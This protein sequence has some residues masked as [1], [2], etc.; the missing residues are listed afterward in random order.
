L[1]TDVS[2]HWRGP[3]WTLALLLAGLTMLGPFAIDTYLPAFSGIARSLGAT[4][5]QMQQTLS[6]YLF[7]FGVMN[8]FH[9]ALADAFGRRPVVLTGIAVFTLASLGCALSQSI[10]ML[11]ACRALQGL[12]AG[13]GMVVSRVIVRD[14]YPPVEAQRMLSQVSMWFG[15]APAVAPMIGGVLFDALGWHAVFWL[16]VVLG[17][18]L[19]LVNWRLL[20]ETLKP[21]QRQPFHPR[22]LLRAYVQLLAD[23]RF[24]ALTVASGIPFNGMF[25][26][27]LSA[28]AFL[29]EHLRLAP[30]QF[31]WFFLI[32]VGGMMSGAWLS[33]RLAG[34]ITPREQIRWGYR[35]ML[36]VGALNVLQTWLLPAHPVW[37]IVPIGLYALGWSMMTPVVTLLL[38]DLLPQRRGMASSVQSSISS[39]TNGLVAGVLAPL[40]MHSALALA[41]A[42]LALGASGLLSWTWVKTRLPGY[43]N[44]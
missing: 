4:P 7:S 36:S 38:L 8:L 32:N 9:G 30:T 33:G 22:P 14:L 42:S 5:S 44:R 21:E 28:P 37:S 10:G 1:T 27:V 20:P 19:G 18:A 16:L 3:R 23:P 17:C 29:G 6:A 39:M 40:V 31:F 15:V 24:L 34:K 35:V 43:S 13:A 25:L 11:V 12:S 2:H 26:Y 41:L